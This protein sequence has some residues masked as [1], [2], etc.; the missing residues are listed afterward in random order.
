MKSMTGYAE[1]QVTTAGGVVEFALRSVNGRFLDIK[2]HLPSSLSSIEKDLREIIS[3]QMSRGTLSVTLSKRTKG[4]RTFRVSTDRAKAVF[5]DLK[6]LSKDLGLKNDV[7]LKDLLSFSPFLTSDDTSDVLSAADHKKILAGLR[8]TLKKLEAEKLR[9][10]LQLQRDILGRL[11]QIEDLV[12]VI[13]QLRAGA[14]KEVRERLEKRIADLKLKDFDGERLSQEVVWSI[15]KADI[16]EE[17]TRL[18]EHLRHI[19]KLMESKEGSGKK[20][21]FY[22]QELLREINTIGAKANHSGITESV[23]EVKTLV[24]Q[25][26]EQVQNLE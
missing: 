14:Q 25:I 23:V 6:K 8:A 19:K 3:G 22:T 2:F 10:G 5:Q 26:K 13:S 4:E 16:Q 17:L 20:L 1:S 7:T 11:K 9:E 18:Q 24:D 12:L 15:E 21:D